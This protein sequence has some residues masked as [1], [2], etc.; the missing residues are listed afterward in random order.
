MLTRLLL[1]GAVIAL[2]LSGCGRNGTVGSEGPGL[3]GPT[4]V[5]STAASARGTGLVTMA[6]REVNVIMNDACDPETFNAAIGA[7]TCL[8][9][10]GVTFQDFIAQLTKH[11][12]V[13]AWFFAPRVANVRVGDTF[14]VR[15]Q[16]GE[17]HTFTEVEEFGG[18]VVP[19]LN[20]LAGVPEEAPE[21][22]VLEEEDRVPSGGVYTE[23][24]E[25]T[26]HEKYQCCIHPWMRLEAD[27]KPAVHTN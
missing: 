11:A 16:G 17:E 7:G 3:V 20:T 1:G 13:G 24:I 22:K 27:I 25:E 12:S 26:G 21:C 2:L 14:V 8:R 18:G 23:H 15:N 19:L 5:A 10:G 4:D 6:A 9:N